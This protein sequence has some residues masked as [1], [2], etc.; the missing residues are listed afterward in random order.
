MESRRKADGEKQETMQIENSPET[1]VPPE[2]TRHFR[3][4]RLFQWWAETGDL[5]DK[6]L[7][8]KKGRKTKT[9]NFS[10]EQGRVKKDGS[11]NG[12]FFPLNGS[13]ISQC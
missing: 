1:P 7:G 2:N 10:N 4:G 3:L 12:S 6:Y 13:Y 9:Q 8:R 11:L 5:E